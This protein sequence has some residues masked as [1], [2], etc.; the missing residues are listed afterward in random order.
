MVVYGIAQEKGL[1][2]P[3]PAVSDQKH[4][5]PILQVEPERVISSWRLQTTQALLGPENWSNLFPETGKVE[6]EWRG[7]EQGRSHIFGLGVTTRFG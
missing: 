1:I 4:W 6:T 5:A 2:G 7:Y 3:L